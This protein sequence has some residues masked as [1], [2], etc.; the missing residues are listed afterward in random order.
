[1]LDPEVCDLTQ[2]EVPL[3]VLDVELVDHLVLDGVQS[4]EGSGLV[5]LEAGRL[6]IFPDN[7]EQSVRCQ[8]KRT[9]TTASN[10]K[11]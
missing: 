4:F 5:E 10:A 1:M 7:S 3:R 11:R 2:L 8:S 6:D 9:D